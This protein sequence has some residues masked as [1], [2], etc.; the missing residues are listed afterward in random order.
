M[1]KP[2][3]T[4]GDL[5]R[6]IKDGTHIPVASYSVSGEYAMV[7]A[8]AQAGFVDESSIMCEMAVSAYRAGTDLYISYFAKELAECIERGIIG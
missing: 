1:V 7:K 5:I 6:E 4:Y 3:M 2:A 8:A